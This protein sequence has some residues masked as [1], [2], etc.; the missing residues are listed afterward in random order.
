VL[1]GSDPLDFPWKAMWCLKVC[2]RVA[3]SVWTTSWGKILTITNLIKQVMLFVNRCCMCK[4]HGEY[5]DH[6]L[7]YCS[8]G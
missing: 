1:R 7:L 8:I 3:F 5:L 2:L 6:M 4:Q